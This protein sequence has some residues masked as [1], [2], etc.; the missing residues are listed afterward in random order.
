MRIAFISGE[1]P[2]DSGKGGIG[3][4]TQQVSGSLAALGWDVH[5]FAYSPL[6]QA[7]EVKES[8]HIHWVKC[9]QPSEFSIQ[10]LRTFSKEHLLQE[11][12]IMESP[13]I[14]G[15]AKLI[16]ETFPGISLIVRLHGPG[17]LVESLKKMYIP[18]IVKLKFVAGS[19]KQLKPNLGYWRHYDK[20]LDA[21]YKFLQAANFITTPSH[22]MKQWAL[23]HWGIHENNITVIPNIFVPAPGWLSIQVNPKAINRQV[24]FFGRLNVLKGLVNLCKAMKKVL[25]NNPGWKFIIIGN[26]G[27]GPSGNKISMKEWI[28]EYFKDVPDKVKFIDGLD[29]EKL[30]AAI[31]DAEI[32]ALP[33][34]FES[35]S[36]T[37][38]EAMAAGKAVVGSRNTGMSDLIQNNK[39]GLLIDPKN[40]SQI[41]AAI[42]KLIK[43][44]QLR[45]QLS[46]N[47]REKI[48]NQFDIKNTIKAFNSFYLHILENRIIK[49]EFIQENN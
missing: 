28:R 7:V 36:Y 23:K 8:V 14:G 21:D 1:F 29:Y 43:D 20:S 39:S 26:D 46:L 33:S 15:N 34:L 32:I 11:F 35:F 3:T 37:C 44:D 42:N 13:E 48:Q 49:N 24:V 31:K 12:E 10:V 9:T 6:R 17:Y 38:A 4:Y 2:P 16:K 30:P 27:P 45:Y 41:Y 40:V 5:V 25:I 47:A 22:A 19:L 18:F